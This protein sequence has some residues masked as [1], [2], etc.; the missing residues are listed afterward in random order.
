[1]MDDPCNLGRAF[2]SQCDIVRKGSLNFEDF[3]VEVYNNVAAAL[4]LDQ[5]ETIARG[6]LLYYL[7]SQTNI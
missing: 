7:M 6:S 4:C 2:V 3:L 1:M 5:A